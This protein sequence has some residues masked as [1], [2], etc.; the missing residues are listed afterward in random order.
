MD[1]S[2]RCSSCGGLLQQRAKTLDLFATLF[3][4]WRYPDFTFRK[5]ILAEHR[6]YAFLIALFEAVGM[7]FLFLF[8]VKAGDIFSI[9]LIR[10]LSTG[11]GF[12]VAAYLPFLYLFCLLSYF[13]SRAS[14]TGASLR[15][16]MAGMIYAMHPIAVS[17]IVILP[18]EV[19]VFGPYVFSNNPSPLTINP[20]PFYLLGILDCLLGFAAIMFVARLSKLLFGTR[21]KAIIF[22]GIFFI[23][24]IVSVELTK[25]ILVG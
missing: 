25:R 19:A 7:S 22:V 12:A 14:Q 20:A 3:N 2:L 4:V 8:T 17:A 18:L 13:L 6:N 21:K 15:G 10:L 11:L 24:F 16:F 9:E 23:L 1:L 5:I